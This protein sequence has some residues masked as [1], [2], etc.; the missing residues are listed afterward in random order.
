MALVGF[1]IPLLDGI[2]ARLCLLL[3]HAAVS[4]PQGWEFP[5]FSVLLEWFQ[6]NAAWMA[7]LATFRLANKSSIG[8]DDLLKP[9]LNSMMI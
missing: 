5:S 1:L 4:L 8:R 6:Q 7:A 9:G 2:C 3:V